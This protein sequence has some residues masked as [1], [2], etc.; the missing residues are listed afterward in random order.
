MTKNEIVSKIQEIILSDSHLRK[1]DFTQK[2]IMLV[3]DAFFESVKFGLRNNEHIELRGFGTFENR[4]R[5]E[6]RAINPRTKEEVVVE[7]HSI[8]IFR[9]GKEMKEQVRQLDVE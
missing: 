9:P 4:I 2:N 8:P 6:K 3:L 1:S 5:Q 7:K